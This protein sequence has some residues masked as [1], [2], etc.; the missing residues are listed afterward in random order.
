MTEILPGVHH[1]TTHHERIGQPVHSCLVVSESEGVL[2][3]P[4]VPEEGLDWFE[5]VATPTNAY[6]TNRHHYRHAGRFRGRYGATVWCHHAGHHEFEEGA[7]VEPLEFGQELPG[8]VVALQVGVLCEEETA[9]LFR[10]EGGILA[11]GD[12][13]ILYETE[14][15]FV[16]DEYMGEDPEAVKEGLRDSLGQLLDRDFRHL[17]MAHGDPIVDDGKRRLREFVE[18]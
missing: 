12:S 5:D 18:R 4:R 9:F 6:L 17:L 16:P 10:K 1:W 11:L 8:D 2:I 14:L 7:E 3:D 15:A 13:V